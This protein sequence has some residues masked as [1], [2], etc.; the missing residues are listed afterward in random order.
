MAAV[1]NDPQAA[2]ALLASQS[3]PRVEQFV[4]LHES[5][6]SWTLPLMSNMGGC[7]GQFPE[8]VV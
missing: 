3:P 1:A 7:P 8:H 5:S 2:V 4:P 6:H